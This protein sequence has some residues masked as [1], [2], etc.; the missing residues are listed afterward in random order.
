MSL[1]FIARQLDPSDMAFIHSTWYKGAWAA[2]PNCFIPSELFYPIQNKHI[3]RC[4]NEAST[5]VFCHADD[6]EELFG[7][8]N[9]TK[10][11]QALFIHWMYIRSMWRAKEHLAKDMLKEIQNPISNIL[12]LTQYSK[13]FDRFKNSVVFDPYFWSK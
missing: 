9:Y 6:P 7:Y 13:H 12:I 5:L 1:P 10:A 4:L 3:D 8:I 2:K 11:P